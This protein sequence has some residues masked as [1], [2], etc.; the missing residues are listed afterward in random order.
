[1]ARW[2]GASSNLSGWEEEWGVEAGAE[3]QTE[4]GTDAALLLMLSL[5]LLLLLLL[6]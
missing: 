1:M 6:F 4:G 3:L 2:K 5:L